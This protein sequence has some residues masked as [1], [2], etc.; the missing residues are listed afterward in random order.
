MAKEYKKKQGSGLFQG[1]FMAYFILLLHV[2]LLAGLGCLVLFFRGFVQYMLW[3]FLGGASLITYS[4]YKILK[5]MK[6]EKRNFQDLLQL[7]M[8]NGRSLEID[9]L[10]GLASFK[11]G[12]SKNNI[13]SMDI[14]NNSLVPQLEDPGASRIRKLSELANLYENNLITLD[15]YNLG[16]K[17]ILS[18]ITDEKTK[19]S[20]SFRGDIL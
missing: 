10:G 17:Q 6:Q 3:I 7:P 4:G 11:V 14:D 12:S 9:F 18:D 1:I 5:R 13:I 15:E 2:V 20:S 19:N 16:K 8:L